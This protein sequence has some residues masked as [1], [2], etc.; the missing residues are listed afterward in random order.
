MYRKGDLTQKSV[1]FILYAKYT[2]LLKIFLLF[3][4][5]FIKHKLFLFKKIL[6]NLVCD[7]LQLV[8]LQKITFKVLNYNSLIVKESFY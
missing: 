2:R 3:Y 1:G 7:Q 8:I 5:H 6:I 4:Y